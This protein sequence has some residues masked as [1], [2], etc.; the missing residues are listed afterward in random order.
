MPRRMSIGAACAL[1][2][3]VALTGACRRGD[4]ASH[5]DLASNQARSAS[6]P[7]PGT[8]PAASAPPPPAQPAH[9]SLRHVHA[10]DLVSQADMSALLGAPIGKPVGE[11]SDA[12]T[13]CAYPPGEAGSWAQAE[14]AIQWN[15]HG[16]A[17]FG[18][19][20]TD[21]FGGNAVGRQVAHSVA[22]GDHASYSQEGILSIRLGT[23]L[24]TITVP[25]RANWSSRRRRSEGE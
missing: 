12:K 11:N 10:C 22:L 18:E 25:M 8:G 9:T 20:M 5:A 19:Q 24:I 3:A 1:T 2:A 15:A 16:G 7:A 21:A 6:V 17:T 4:P 23:A 14:I 13:S